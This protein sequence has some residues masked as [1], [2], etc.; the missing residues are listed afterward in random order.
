MR[1]LSGGPLSA[2]DAYHVAN[3]FR[4]DSGGDNY[5]T[6]GG[7]DGGLSFLL[8]KPQA[9]ARCGFRVRKLI[10]YERAPSPGAQS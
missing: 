3:L 9:L 8:K 5:L 6:L 10:V 4:S 2:A 1:N 7:I